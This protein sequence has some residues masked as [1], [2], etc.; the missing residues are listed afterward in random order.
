MLLS[1]IANEPVSQGA[2]VAVLDFPLGRI[3]NIDPLFFAN[4]RSVGI[5]VDTVPSGGLCRVISKG[6]ANFF[7]GLEVGQTYYAPLSGSAPS[8]YSEFVDIFNTLEASGAYLCTLGKA[9]SPTTLSI[10]LDTPILV[11]KDSLN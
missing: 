6:E 11:Q 5:A 10:N 4:A 9:I 3:S 1:F 2:A 7:N 8:D